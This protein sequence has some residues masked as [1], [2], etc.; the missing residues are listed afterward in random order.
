[1][2]RKQVSAITQKQAITNPVL[3]SK[4]TAIPHS[5]PGLVIYGNKPLLSFQAFL[6]LETK[7]NVRWSGD[8]ASHDLYKSLESD[9]FPQFLDFAGNHISKKDMK[10]II[11]MVHNQLSQSE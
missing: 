9:A 10:V 7:T 5:N 1:M 8:R 3:S 6:S 2:S 11:F 4:Y